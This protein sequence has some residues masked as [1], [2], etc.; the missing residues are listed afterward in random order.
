[1]HLNQRRGWPFVEDL[2]WRIGPPQPAQRSIPCP[3]VLQPI[4]WLSFAAVYSPREHRGS[5]R[6]CCVLKA[7]CERDTA[8]RGDRLGCTPD[9]DATGQ[10]LTAVGGEPYDLRPMIQIFLS[11]NTRDR[12]WCEWLKASA[13][14]LGIRAYLAEHD[15]QPGEN[16]A[17]KVMYAIDASEAVV[18]LLSSNSV[19][20]PYVHQDRAIQC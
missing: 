4:L 15:V 17:K 19:E 14:E 12:E 1:M 16:L 5:A 20:A 7:F 9:P 13:E 8:I 18:V 2:I 6:A 3:V 11:H 10:P